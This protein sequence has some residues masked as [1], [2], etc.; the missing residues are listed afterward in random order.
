MNAE[1]MASLSLKEGD[2]VSMKSQTG[3]MHNLAVKTFHL[4]R[5]NLMT[6][7]PE[8]N[9]LVGRDRD[10]RS[11]TPAFKSISVALDPENVIPTV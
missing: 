9:V 10:P 7:Y 5:G 1:D 6:Y 11:K 2:L 8:A 4:P 3:V